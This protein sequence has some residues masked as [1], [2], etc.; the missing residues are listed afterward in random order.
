VFAAGDL[1]PGTLLT[2]LDMIK[3]YAERFLHISFALGRTRELCRNEPENLDRN[4]EKTASVL[5]GF[6]AML[7][8]CEAAG[9]SYCVP[10]VRRMLQALDEGVSYREMY[11]MAGQMQDRLNDELTS[12]VL[13]RIP[14]DCAALYDQEQLFGQVVADAF[15]SAKFDIWEAGNCF[16]AERFTAS[17]F[18]LMRVLEIGLAAFASVFSIP[19]DHT[20]WQTIIDQIEKHVRD[21]P[22]APTKA[23]D[24]K[25]KQEF[26]SQAASSFMFFKDAWRNYTAHAR[27][28]YV[29][30][31]ADTILGNVRAFM[32]RLAEGGIKET[33]L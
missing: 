19:A 5:T 12:V 7:A 18:H 29:E 24:W 31:E 20:N 16:A 9:L 8:D 11:A 1:K 10:H 26:Y 22:K 17:V 23:A 30:H 27:G 6:E 2:L 28:K 4:F 3:F 13:L 15:P 25:E 21:M 32:Q 14:A 33:P